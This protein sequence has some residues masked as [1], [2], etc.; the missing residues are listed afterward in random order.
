MATVKKN[1]FKKCKENPKFYRLQAY[2][3]R[4][5]VKKEKIRKIL[6]IWGSLHLKEHKFW[7]NLNPTQFTNAQINF[8][9]TS[10]IT[11]Q[12]KLRFWNFK[13]SF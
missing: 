10:L 11:Y 2:T 3:S 4:R 7:S 1:N 5:F 9:S 6:S 12:S 8:Y 13:H